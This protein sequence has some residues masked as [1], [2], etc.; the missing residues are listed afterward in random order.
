[1]GSE[2]IFVSGE[3]FFYIASEHIREFN[4]N[5]TVSK[6]SASS[7][8]FQRTQFVETVP[9]EKGNFVVV[10]LGS[11]EKVKLGNLTS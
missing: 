1:M 10:C 7:R 3:M 9:K 4:V 5:A 8:L 2:R 6:T 11:S